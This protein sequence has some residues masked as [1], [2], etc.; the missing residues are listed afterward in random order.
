MKI[1]ISFKKNSVNK[2]SIEVFCRSSISQKIL[3]KVMANDFYLSIF[4]PRIDGI[5]IQDAVVRKDKFPTHGIT[6]SPKSL[7]NYA[8]Y[9]LQQMNHNAS[10]QRCEPF[11]DFKTLV[12]YSNK[13]ISEIINRIPTP[14]ALH[15]FMIGLITEMNN[16]ANDVK[17]PFKATFE[18]VHNAYEESYDYFN[19]I[20]RVN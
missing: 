6:W 5:D 9:V 18:N 17:Q 4:Y 14:R 10:Q 2:A 20:H 1:N 13:K 8:D 7:I 3:S 16:D 19:K 11:T 12:N 15:Y